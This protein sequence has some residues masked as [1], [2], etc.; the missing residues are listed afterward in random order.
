MGMQYQYRRKQLLESLPEDSLIIMRGENLK[1]RSLDQNFPFW[2]SGSFYYLTGWVEPQATMVL[3]KRAGKAKSLLF[4]KGQNEW[5]RKWH[6]ENIS[7]RQAQLSY[8]FDESYLIDEFP[9]W[10][11]GNQSHFRTV[12]VLD[13][14]PKIEWR[15][16]LQIP[17]IDQVWL[18]E[19]IMQMRLK[20]INLSWNSL[21]RHAKSQPARTIK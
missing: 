16:I 17:M 15:G 4:H 21:Q 2:Q 9:T 18:S 6:G 11:H 12:F 10:L 19:K 5:D 8:H 3:V 7:Q 14:G 1:Q 20:K 13:E